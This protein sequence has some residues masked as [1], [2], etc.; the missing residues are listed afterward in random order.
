MDVQLFFA[1]GVLVL[2][3]HLYIAN[4]IL[5]GGYAKGSYNKYY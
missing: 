5:P 1:N 4:A 3:L 2:C